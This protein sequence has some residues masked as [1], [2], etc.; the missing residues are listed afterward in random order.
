MAQQYTSLP[1]KPAILKVNFSKLHHGLK[2]SL[3]LLTQCDHFA[4]P[5][6]HIEIIQP[7]AIDTA[8]FGSGLSLAQKTGI[9]PG[10]ILRL[11]CFSQNLSS[12]IL[13]YINHVSSYP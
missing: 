10:S 6:R 11:A 7:S 4:D 8:V 13:I 9:K 3:Q 5:G 2:T 12:M 1:R